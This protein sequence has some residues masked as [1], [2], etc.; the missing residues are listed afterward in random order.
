[1]NI[2]EFLDLPEETRDYLLKLDVKRKQIRKTAESIATDRF[3]LNNR[4][5]NNQMQCEHWFADKTYKA[6]ENEFGNYTGGGEYRYHCED[7]GKR[8]SEE[9]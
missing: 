7:C 9:K 3:K 8:W 2:K 5:L 1:M 6:H 4:E